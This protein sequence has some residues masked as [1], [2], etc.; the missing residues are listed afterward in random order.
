MTRWPVWGMGAVAL[1][2]VLAWLARDEP[3]TPPAPAPAPPAASLE[4][5]HVPPPA[6]AA[7]TV[8]AAVPTAPPP[9]PAWDLC[10]L[11]RMPATGPATAPDALPTPIG[12]DSLQPWLPDWKARLAGADARGQ[13]AHLLFAGASPSGETDTTTEQ[14]VQLARTARDPVVW[15]WAFGHCRDRL[16][17]GACAR[18]DPADWARDDPGNALPWLMLGET[19]PARRRQ[20]LAEAARA[21]RVQ[22]YAGQLVD[23]V[24]RAAPPGMPRYLRR[25]PAVDAMGTEAQFGTPALAYLTDYCGSPQGRAGERQADC[26]AVAEHLAQRADRWQQVGLGITLGERLGWPAER[27]AAL[28]EERQR[29]EQLTAMPWLTQPEQAY[30]CEVIDGIERWVVGVSGQGEVGLSRQARR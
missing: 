13:A 25:Q 12:E 30:S 11:G 4:R 28:K 16:T 3:A 17:D 7:S 5:P 19:D 10:G 20:A 2:A 8:A 6:A 1:A 24:W 15:A 29:G 26:Q 18:L 9:R 23:R 27:L 22:T 14:L 21:N